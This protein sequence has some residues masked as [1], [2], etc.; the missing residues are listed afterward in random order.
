MSNSKQFLAMAV[1]LTA[2]ATWVGQASAQG[3]SV[4]GGRSFRETHTCGTRQV[5]GP[6]TPTVFGP[7]PQRT[8]YLNRNGGTYTIVNGAT[9]SA[10]NQVN[11]NV[12]AQGRTGNVTIA[13]M[14][15][16]FNW[17]MIAACVTEHYRP[18]N[19]RVTETEPSSGNYVEAVV[20]G[21]GTE[22]GFGSNELFGIA[23]ADNFC[24]V[25]ERGV[26]F[27]FPE[28][29]RGVPSSDVELCATIAHEV[30]HV[31]GLE[32]EALPADVMSYVLV[33]ELPRGT[34][35]DFVDQNSQCG[36]TPQQ[37]NPC[38][39]GGATA[40]S[41][42]RLS[43]FLGVRPLETVP[44]TLTVNAPNDG[45]TVPTTFQVDADATDN[46]EVAAVTVSIDGT[47]VGSDSTPSGDK[48]L[49]TVS[50]VGE[51]PHTMTVTARDT[52]GNEV[53][54]D[55]NITV[56]LDCGDCGEGYRCVDG[57]CLVD[58]GYQCEDES[59][60][61]GGLCIP[62][63]AGMICSTECDLGGDNTCGSGLDC[64]DGG[65]I[66]VCVPAADGGDGGGGCCSASTSPASMFALV[67]LVGLVLGRRR[68]TRR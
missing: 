53:S 6:L 62:D 48:Y 42:Q 4:G 20:G 68:R 16:G 61:A 35:K 67:G 63:Q 58:D 12:H 11:R 2:S 31:V 21:N 26:A 40:N 13:P 22:L 25:T 32:H 7:Q 54:E 24:G 17:A 5:P 28:T 19:I 33:D 59:F 51:G 39:C 60:C 23:A 45:G 36:T 55:R 65:G 15:A 66:G 43:N 18:Y 34:L 14:G 8:I 49:I 9:N 30:G 47:E 37:T 44:P 57:T 64:V 1:A 27:S 56:S 3:V 52:S 46:E 50:N 38:S 29:H 41:H 10:T